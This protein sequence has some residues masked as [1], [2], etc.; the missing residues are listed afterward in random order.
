MRNF[1][2][3]PQN[4]SQFFWK[5]SKLMFFHQKNN[6]F[7]KIFS[8]KFSCTCRYISL[9]CI[10][11]QLFFIL[12]IIQLQRSTKIM[13]L[14]FFK[15]FVWNVFVKSFNFLNCYMR[16][17]T[18]EWKAVYVTT[19]WNQIVFGIENTHFIWP[20][21]GSTK[22]FWQKWNHTKWRDI[23]QKWNSTSS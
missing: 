9:Y 6:V 7:S 15:I 18:P 23:L 14:K 1:Q 11:K 17:F 4:F 19:K 20:E 16:G 3:F 22:V 10:S 2:S 21:Q 12:W 13:K 5:I 8:W